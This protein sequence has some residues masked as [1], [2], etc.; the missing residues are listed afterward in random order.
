VLLAAEVVLRHAAGRRVLDV[1]AAVPRVATLVRARAATFAT[2]TPDE[3][4]RLAVAPASFDLAYTLRTLPYLDPDPVVSLAR[5]EMLVSELAIAVA[6][7]GFVVFDLDNPQSLRGALH[8][9][10]NPGR[11]ASV[12]RAAPVVVQT[13]AGPDRFDWLGPFLRRL[14]RFLEVCHVHGIQVLA[15]TPEL[16][17][18]PLL[19]QLAARAEWWL[20]DL[21]IA[22]RFGAHLVVV[23]RR[24]AG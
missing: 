19:G 18:A 11:V 13:P 3:A 1:G 21:A 10:R 23:A 8:G 16:Y 12:V 4:G 15:A 17:R 9:V 22:R 7:G 2:A 6:P 14:P 24:T 5:A 20:R